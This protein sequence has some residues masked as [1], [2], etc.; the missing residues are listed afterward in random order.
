[1]T[2]LS[3]DDPVYKDYMRDAGAL[4]LVTAM[5]AAYQVPANRNLFRPIAALMV[6]CLRILSHDDDISKEQLR[7][8]GLID[9]LVTG[10]WGAPYRGRG[11]G[12]K[13]WRAAGAKQ[14]WQLP[15]QA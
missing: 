6:R 9:M 12:G 2:C 15:H 14:P 5:L 1:M 4:R 10:G 7:G 3:D 13:G 8:L 11:A